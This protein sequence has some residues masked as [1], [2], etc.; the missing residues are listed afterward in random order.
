MATLLQTLRA[1]SQRYKNRIGSR[2]VE[3][4]LSSV[5]LPLLTH[6]VQLSGFRDMK[7]HASEELE[8]LKRKLQ[9]STREAIL[10][11]IREQLTAQFAVNEAPQVRAV[12]DA[13]DNAG[14]TFAASAT[15]AAV[16][17][18]FK[19]RMLFERYNRSKSHKLRLDLQARSPQSAPSQLVELLFGQGLALFTAAIRAAGHERLGALF[20]KAPSGAGRRTQPPTFD[21]IYSTICK[22]LDS[23]LGSDPESQMLVRVTKDLF[24][25]ELAKKIRAAAAAAQQELS[26]ARLHPLL[27]SDDDQGVLKRALGD[28]HARLDGRHF[29]S[30]VARMAF[31]A[32]LAPN[33]ATM[34]SVDVRTHVAARLAEL[35]R[36]FTE[37]VMQTCRSVFEKLV[38][39]DGEGLASLE[40][41]G[42]FRKTDAL[43]G[44]LRD[45][46]E[47]ATSLPHFALSAALQESVHTAVEGH[48]KLLELLEQA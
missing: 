38:S 47:A 26:Y 30:N 25:V 9:P 36:R 20:F 18:R 44:E 40:S 43:A 39:H 6:A 14:R 48:K 12:R 41:T 7:K 29:N 46:A 42:V 24:R 1:N 28:L 11:S 2:V 15:R 45:L 37:V 19:D 5:V 17:T 34:V 27:Y 35:E 16:D 21:N 4:L 32:P 3:Q 22:K 31:L 8:A 33:A 13:V 10:G 23:L